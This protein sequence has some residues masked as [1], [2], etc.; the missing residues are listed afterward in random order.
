M[1]KIGIIAV[2]VLVLAGGVIAGLSFYADQQAEQAVENFLATTKGITKGVYGE[3]ESSLFS[4]QVAVNNL[5]FD[6]EREGKVSVKVGRASMDLAS[7]EVMSRILAPAEGEKAIRLEGLITLSKVSLIKPD[8][9]EVAFDSLS[10]KNLSF[11]PKAWE[12]VE[13]WE[14]F[15][16]AANTV[17]LANV[18]VTDLVFSEDGKEEAKIRQVVIDN[19]AQA[20]LGKLEITDFDASASMESTKEKDSVLKLKKLSLTGV[21]LAAMDKVYNP[22]HNKGAANDSPPQSLVEGVLFSGFTFED[23]HEP[24]SISMEEILFSKISSSPVDTSLATG[25]EEEQTRLAAKLA[26]AMAINEITFKNLKIEATGGEVKGGLDLGSISFKGYDQGALKESA[27]DNFDLKSDYVNVALENAQTNDLNYRFTLN[28]LANGGD[29]S[30]YQGP[31]ID[32]SGKGIVTNFSISVPYIDLEFQVPSS[33]FT[34]LVKKGPENYQGEW[35][36]PSLTIQPMMTANPVDPATAYA[37]RRIWDN[38]GYEVMNLKMGGK[39]DINYSTLVYE[40]KDAYLDIKDGGIVKKNLAVTVPDPRKVKMPTSS[41]LE[42]TLSWLT[43]YKLKNLALSYEDKSLFDR[44]MKTVA[45]EAGMEPQMLKVTILA[46]LGMQRRRYQKQPGMVACLDALSD[47]V[48]KPGKLI[49]QVNPTRPA[50]MNE[51]MMMGSDPEM[52]IRA[53]NLRLVYEE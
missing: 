17:K 22:L 50:G 35:T 16:R 3:I 12:K 31:P 47:F 5:S 2:L 46:Q 25:S 34:G 20:R 37:V 19:V 40:L 41:N 48:A 43:H 29:M 33:D 24:V 36:V 53:L 23:A 49:L 52:I 7:M 45:K 1:K 44:I 14:D 18:V 6:Y 21:D 11:E 8:K 39:A 42:D 9:E 38:L 26:L 13:E 15:L 10:L 30:S 51:F 32:I 4:S 28:T 27:I